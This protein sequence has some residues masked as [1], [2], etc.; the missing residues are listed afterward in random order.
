MT[1]RETVG[2]LASQIRGVTYKAAEAMTTPMQGYVG[3]VRAGNIVDGELTTSDLVYVPS[4]CVRD[5]QYLRANDVLIATSSGSIDIVGKAARIRSDESIAFGAFCKVLRPSGRVDPRYFAHFF[6]TETYRR[7]VANVAAGS[8][9]NNLKKG[10]LDGL[11]ILLPT[12]EEQ[13]RIAAI[14]DSVDALKE[15]HRRALEE[16]NALYGT[17]SRRAFR[18]EL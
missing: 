3:V 10:D 6:L 7:Y 12:L 11:E 4:S 18:G 2:Q 13:R 14:L 9:I 5:E 15:L 17:L 1:G 8:N 16:V